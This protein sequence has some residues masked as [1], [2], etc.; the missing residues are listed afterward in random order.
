LPVKGSERSW[1]SRKP[2]PGTNSAA[3]IANTSL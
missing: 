1:A 3:T 2:S